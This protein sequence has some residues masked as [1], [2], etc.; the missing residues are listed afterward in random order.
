M[1][2]FEIASVSPCLINTVGYQTACPD[3][4]PIIQSASSGKIYTS[5]L[6]FN[7]VVSVR[8]AVER[9]LLVCGMWVKD[10]VVVGGFFI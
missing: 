6:R 5:S 1:D 10:V 3:F 7:F 9:T 8:L 2:R 4:L